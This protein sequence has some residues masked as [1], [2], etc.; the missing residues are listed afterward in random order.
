MYVVEIGMGRLRR[1]GC[2][3]EGVGMVGREFLE[4]GVRLVRCI[5]FDRAVSCTNKQTAQ[6]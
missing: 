3:V 1:R 4:E 2:G 5:F 6:S